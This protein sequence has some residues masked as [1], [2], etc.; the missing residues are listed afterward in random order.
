MTQRSRKSPNTLRW[1]NRCVTGV[2]S[3]SCNFGY[4]HCPLYADGWR[5]NEEV[6]R[7]RRGTL[8]RPYQTLQQY[9]KGSNQGLLL[10]PSDQ[11]I[12]S[13]AVICY[14]S[15]ANHMSMRSVFAGK[16]PDQVDAMDSLS[17]TLLVKWDHWVLL[18]DG[19]SNTHPAEREDLAQQ[20]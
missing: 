7:K 11:H 17:A 10:L 12:S 19:R 3:N 1:Q 18:P 6:D 4:G 13:V 9:G 14:L 5:R 2:A 15:P 16:A 20:L 8:D